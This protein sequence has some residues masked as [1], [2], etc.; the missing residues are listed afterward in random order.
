MHTL[1]NKFYTSDP[2]SNC[3]E[4]NLSSTD[5]IMGS[6]QQLEQLVG[7]RIK[8][9]NLRVIIVLFQWS[10]VELKEMGALLCIASYNT[11]FEKR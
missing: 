1:S 5:E 8:R 2:N 3:D 7:I 11:L 10:N 6:F 4:N 9:K